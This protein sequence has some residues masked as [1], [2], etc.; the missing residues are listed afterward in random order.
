MARTLKFLGIVGG[1]PSPWLYVFLVGAV[2]SM[3]CN[4]GTLYLL[5]PW[6]E[7]KIAPKLPLTTDKKEVTVVIHAY[8]AHPLA[9]QGNFVGDLHGVDGDLSERLTAALKKR[10]DDNRDRIKIIPHYQ[11]RSFV[12]RNGDSR[13][14]SAHEIGKHFNADYVISLEINNLSL[15]EGGSSRQL[16]RGRTE[17]SVTVFD[18]SKPREEGLVMDETYRAEYPPTGPEDAG[19]SSALQFR[20]RF[21]TQIS[22]EISRWFAATVREYDI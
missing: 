15:Y 11:V 8:F 13:L 17:L 12:N 6:M 14:V 18:M 4:P 21:L 5:M 7:D 1:K 16:L 22:R 19:S 20:N 3:G 9:A 2:M 10:Y